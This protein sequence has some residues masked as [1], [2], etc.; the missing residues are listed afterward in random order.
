M[1]LTPALPLP[2]F[3]MHATGDYQ[4][5]SVPRPSINTSEGGMLLGRTLKAS[6]PALVLFVFLI[7]ILTIVFGSLMFFFEMGTFMVRTRIGEGFIHGT[8]VNGVC[9]YSNITDR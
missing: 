7:T 1:H 2:I 8:R 9:I 4:N 3:W 5:S 6:L